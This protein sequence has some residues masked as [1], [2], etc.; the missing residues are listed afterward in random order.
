[1]SFWSIQGYNNTNVYFSDFFFKQKNFD[2]WM[3]EF[4][5]YLCIWIFKSSLKYGSIV[6]LSNYFFFV[7]KS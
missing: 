2:G 6:I 4:I 3:N 7:L 1:M 5:I